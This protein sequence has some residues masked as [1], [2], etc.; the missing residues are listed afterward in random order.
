MSPKTTTEVVTKALARWSR[1]STRPI[2]LADEAQA[3]PK[4]VFTQKATS[5]KMVAVVEVVPID[6]DGYA[7]TDQLS[8]E[9]SARDTGDGNLGLIE[10]SAPRSTTTPP[11]P[12]SSHER[13]C[14]AS[15]AWTT[16]DENIKAYIKSDTALATSI[17]EN[18]GRSRAC[19]KL[20]L[21]SQPKGRE[22]EIELQSY[23]KKEDI[24]EGV[25]P[26]PPPLRICRW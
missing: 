5:T 10:S 6:L 21:S 19:R 13:G 26:D 20:R 7:T 14:K 3:D 2:R 15:N 8:A 22:P 23:A 25:G 9:A 17:D 1:A 24:P 12:S 16:A 11:P 18:A 4:K